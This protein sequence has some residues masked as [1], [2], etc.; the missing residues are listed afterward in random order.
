MFFNEEESIYY[1][2]VDGIPVGINEIEGD[3][4]L[5]A[6]GGQGIYNLAGQRLRKMQKG[7]NIVGGKKILV[8]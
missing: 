2:L 6:D 1:N 3:S 7:I 5:T 8:K 4:Q